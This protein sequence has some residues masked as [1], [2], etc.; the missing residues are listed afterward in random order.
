MAQE[1]RP[2]HLAELMSGAFERFRIDLQ[3]QMGS[4]APLRVSHLRLLDSVDD[5]GTRPS[6]LADRSRITRQG[7]SQLLAHLETHGF[8]SSIRDP[9]DRRATLVTP[10]AAGAAMKSRTATAMAAVEAKW[11]QRLGRDRYLEFTNCLKEVAAADQ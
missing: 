2:P 1:H 5:H 6:A 10:T 4:I 8:V 7:V 9:A 11:Q 3:S